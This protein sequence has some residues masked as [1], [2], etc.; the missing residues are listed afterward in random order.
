MDVNQQLHKYLLDLR[1]TCTDPLFCSRF[2]EYML[3]VDGHARG[4]VWFDIA[5]PG[6]IYFSELIV[7]A[8]QMAYSLTADLY[9]ESD[10]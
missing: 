7:V 2:R 8:V 1:Y 10:S 9:S 3:V 4:M 5:Y 6:M